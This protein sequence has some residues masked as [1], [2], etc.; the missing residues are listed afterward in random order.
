MSQPQVSTATANRVSDQEPEKSMH[1]RALLPNL[2]RGF[3]VLS[4]VN[5]VAHLSLWISSHHPAPCP[6]HSGQPHVSSLAHGAK[7]A[8]VMLLLFVPPASAPAHSLPKTACGL[9]KPSR[10]QFCFFTQPCHDQLFPPLCDFCRPCASFISKN[11]AAPTFF[12]Y[13]DRFLACHRLHL[14]GRN[15]ARLPYLGSRRR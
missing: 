2:T 9:L 6:C 13:S 4:A 12:N 7:A 14:A 11:A 5:W 1:E 15:C 10:E 8:A 3:H